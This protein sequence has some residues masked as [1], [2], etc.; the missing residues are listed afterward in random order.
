M[1]RLRARREQGLVTSHVLRAAEKWRAVHD[2]SGFFHMGMLAG[3][4]PAHRAARQGAITAASGHYST[5]GQG[6][7][8]GRIT[9]NAATAPSTT[10]NG[11]AEKPNRI[12]E[13]M[14][15]LPS[16]VDMFSPLELKEWWASAVP[17]TDL[18][19]AL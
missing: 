5:F 16:A 1:F 14:A 13:T 2:Q 12:T 7:R 3:S 8:R 18:G 10:L 17:P 19:V 4:G 15:A 11:T 6:F 9:K